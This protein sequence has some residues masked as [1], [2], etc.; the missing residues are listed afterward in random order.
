MLKHVEDLEK[1]MMTCT[2]RARLVVFFVII[3]CLTQH[4]EVEKQHWYHFREVYHMFPPG[5]WCKNTCC[6]YLHIQYI[7]IFSHIHT[8][9]TS[10]SI[11][12]YTYFCLI[13]KVYPYGNHVGLHLMRHT[14]P[15]DLPTK[16]SRRSKW[17]LAHS[18]AQGEWDRQ[19]GG[20]WGKRQEVNQSNR[21]WYVVNIMKFLEPQTGCS[22]YSF[23]CLN[24]FVIIWD[25]HL[26]WSLLGG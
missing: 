13:C 5:F 21:T 15:P 2:K 17:D 1:V 19:G 7:Y 20:W 22:K 16:K 23:F 10:Y 14:K 24:H 6:T 9:L 11:I 12:I 26:F 25:Y 3:F 18:P 8:I 4:R